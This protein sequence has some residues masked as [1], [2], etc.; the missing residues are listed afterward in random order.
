MA[1]SPTS[2]R[3]SSLAAVPRSGNRDKAMRSTGCRSTQGVVYHDLSDAAWKATGVVLAALC[4][5]AP[6]VMVTVPGLLNAWQLRGI[7]D[8]CNDTTG[9]H[10]RCCNVQVLLR[11]GGIREGAFNCRDAQ[12]ILFPTGYHTDPELCKPGT[13][14]PYERDL[15][16]DPRHADCI[17]IYGMAQV[18]SLA[19]CVATPWTS[20]V[21]ETH[22]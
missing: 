2:I 3:C 10:I 13:A 6:C 1:A 14:I 9:S 15:E 21:G 19:N 12:F 8:I 18:C 16:W 22:H 11:R 7:G 17:P 4:S 5:C 20:L